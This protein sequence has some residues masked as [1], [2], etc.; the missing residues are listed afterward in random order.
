MSYKLTG[1]QCREFSRKLAEIGRQVGQTEYPY[2]PQRALKALQDLVEGKFVGVDEKIIE[3]E[4]MLGPNVVSRNVQEAKYEGYVNP[5][6]TD[7][8]YPVSG[9]SVVKVRYLLI[10]GEELKR[11]DGWVYRDDFKVYCRERGLREPNAAEALLPPAKDKQLGRGAYPLVA[12]I[13]GS[14]AAFIVNERRRVRSLRQHVVR[15]GWGPPLRVPGRLRVVTWVL[16]A[17]PDSV[18][19]GHLPACRQAGTLGFFPRRSRGSTPTE[20]LPTPRV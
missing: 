2:D 10:S 13:G 17:F 11:T 14:R 4:L 7:E 16:V 1:D 15:G 20:R 3:H 9:E 8:N 12:F 5:A 18:G 6:I 19:I